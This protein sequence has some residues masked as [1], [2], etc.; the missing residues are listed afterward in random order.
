LIEWFEKSIDNEGSALELYDLKNDP[1][2]QYDLFD[3]LPNLSTR[4]HSK[5]KSWRQNVGA[6]EMTKN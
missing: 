5:L 4:M 2:E 6:Q 1:G 3:S